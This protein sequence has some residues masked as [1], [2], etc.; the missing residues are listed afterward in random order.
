MFRTRVPYL[1]ELWRLNF[2]FPMTV[3]YAMVRY[4]LFD[5][6]T[7]IRTGTVY[8]VVTGLV[9]LA[10]AG[11]ITLVNVT[12]ADLGLGR[13]PFVPA[14]VVAVAVVLFLNPVYRRTQAVVDR[15]FFRQRLDVQHSLDRV[16]DAMTTLLDLSRIV[17]LITATV[18]DLFKPTRRAL[19]VL[20][21]AAGA[22]R[23]PLLHRRSRRRERQES[24]AE[25]HGA[26]IAGGAERLA[27]VRD[28]PSVAAVS[29]SSRVTIRAT[30]AGTRRR[31]MPKS[32]WEAAVGPTARSCRAP[33]DPREPDHEQS[34]GHCPVAYGN[35]GGAPRPVL[36]PP[37]ERG[38]EGGGQRGER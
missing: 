31:P 16:S 2:L 27:E 19:L 28:P 20:D 17:Q 8:A 5:L 13:S 4:N 32:A 33:R 7:V 30:V 38:G 23:W 34:A 25:E 29:G 12:F 26:G 3:A 14:A 22:W 37:E 21:E 15:L 10:Y 36:S 1:N 6:R 18:D 24:Q 9:V 35:A 11:A